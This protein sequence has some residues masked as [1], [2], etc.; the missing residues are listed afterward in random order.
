MHNF[1]CIAVDRIE[2]QVRYSGFKFVKSEDSERVIV[3]WWVQSWCDGTEYLC[4]CRVKITRYPSLPLSQSAHTVSLYFLLL[5]QDSERGH[6]LAAVH[7]AI[8]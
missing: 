1:R 3:G 7:N 5:L 8:E 4:L 6:S 2:T